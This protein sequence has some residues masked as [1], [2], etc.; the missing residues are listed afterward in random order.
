MAGIAILFSSEATA[1]QVVA[2]VPAA[3][4]A[5]HQASIALRKRPFSQGHGLVLVAG[6]WQPSPLCRA[7]LMRLAPEFAVGHGVPGALWA[8]PSCVVL[9]GEALVETADIERLLDNPNAPVAGSY[10]CPRDLITGGARA[11]ATIQRERLERAGDTIIAATAKPTDGIVSRHLNR[12]VSQAMT[13]SLLRFP[14]V[15][16]IH[17]TLAAAA[18]GIVMAICLFLGGPGGL[19]AGAILFQLAS[20]V[21]GVDGEVARATFRTS[22]TGAMLDSVTDALTNLAFLAGVSANLWIQGDYGP[23]T[24]GTVGLMLLV[25]GLYLIGATARARGGPFTFDAVKQRVNAR[26]SVIMQWLTWLTMRDFF[27]AAC[28]VMIILDQAGIMLVLFAIVT[29]GWLLVTLA[30]LARPVP[31]RLALQPARQPVSI[32]R[33]GRPG[34]G[35]IRAFR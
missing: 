26:K 20:I 3:A 14:G 15:E 11:S 9:Q 2:G 21:D 24:A 18:I 34:P 13:R 8:N 30:V 23:A 27:A 31:E 29:A 25:T 7:E 19:V 1:N 35:D 12:P 32:A 4:R 17:A 33:A 10:R 6:G 22:R 16:P 28:A 5:A